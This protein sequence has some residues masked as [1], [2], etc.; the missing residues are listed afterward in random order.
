MHDLTA[1]HNTL[2]LGT[3]V[4]VTNLNNGKSVT[5]RINDR[6][7]FVKNRAIDLSYAAAKAIDLVGP[8]TAPVRIEVLSKESP[9]PKFPAY[10]VQVGAFV[11]RE[12]AEALKKNLEKTYAGVGISSFRTANQIYHRVRLKAAT[13]YEAEELAGKLAVQGLTAI[14]FEEK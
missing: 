1:A 7:P 5:V 2:P 10:S 3:L 12:N 8:G 11:S 4:V 13:R 9:P 14:I 6:G